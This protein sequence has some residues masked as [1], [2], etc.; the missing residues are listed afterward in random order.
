MM[1]RWEPG[2]LYNYQDA[3][4][5]NDFFN[6]LHVNKQSWEL[7][8]T[9]KKTMVYAVPAAF[10]TETTSMYRPSINGKEKVAWVYIWQFGLNGKVIYGRTLDEFVDFLSQLTEELDLGHNK[11]LYVYVHNLGYDFQFIR[12]YFKWD[13]VFAAEKRRPIYALT[14]GYEFRDSYILAN[15]KLETVGNNL[16]KYKVEKL[17]GDL[18]YSLI[19]H[20]ETPLTERELAYC[21]NDIRVVMAYIQEKIEQEDGDICAIPLTNTGYVRRHVREKCFANNKKIRNQYATLMR[22]LKISGEEEYTMLLRAFQGGFTHASALYSTQLLENVGS[23]DIASSY[24]VVMCCEYFPMSK[25]KRVEVSQ[26][27][28][29]YYYLKHYCCVFDITFENLRMKVEYETPLS[30]SRCSIK[31][32]YQLNNGRVAF[33]DFCLTTMTE[34]DFDTCMRFYEWDGFIIENMIIYRR[35]YLPKQIIEATLDLY[36]KKTT[37]KGVDEKVIEYMISKNM[38]NSIYGMMVT[39]VVRNEV[40]YDDEAGWLQAC[41]NAFSQLDRYNK[42][43]NRFLYY[44]WGVWVTAHARHNLFTAISEF[45]NDY[46]YCDTDSIK[47]LN[48]ENHKKYFN[49][50]NAQ[51][52]A[53]LLKMCYH[54]G[55]PFE[56]CCPRT[57][58]GVKK[59]LGVWEIEGGYTYFKTCGA[60][61]YMYIEKETGDLNLTVSGLNKEWAVP[62]LLEN[63]NYD[64]GEIFEAFG[65]GFEVPPGHTGKMTLTY[66]DDFRAGAVR[67]YLGNMGTYVAPT[68]IHMEA[69]GY[70][71]GILD[72]Y[73]K[74][75]KGIQEV[76]IT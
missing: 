5:L 42:N 65:L 27:E 64:P 44:A 37:L 24:P 38:I 60:K 20:S 10:D 35:S 62:W 57:I 55:I 72:D 61:R 69:Q 56:K 43:F 30:Y 67:D 74:F 29:F 50:Y 70:R 4:Q 13:N 25:G 52:K 49:A 7:C 2:S 19:R 53:K 36:E 54:Y 26:L 31:G 68:S 46:V 33:A 39:A 21:V 63:Y 18:D 9:G 40:E 58:K 32:D 3:S 23:A 11:R 6:W 1:E 66:I 17:V 45:G 73:I 22:T 8:K 12:K 14:G 34:L 16:E 76:Q 15:S 51:I 41:G 71:M 47:G 48:F 59:P 28:E 75:L